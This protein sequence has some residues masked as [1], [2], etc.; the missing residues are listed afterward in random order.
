MEPSF[1]EDKP[2]PEAEGTREAA[3]AVFA[4]REDRE[5]ECYMSWPGSYNLSMT[6]TAMRQQVMCFL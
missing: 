5:L 4:T 6:D 1:H 3:G 2:Q